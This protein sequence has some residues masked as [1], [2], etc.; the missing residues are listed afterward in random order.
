MNLNDGLLT[1]KNERS[2]RTYDLETESG[3]QVHIQHWFD[4]L[5][6]RTCV[7][8]LACSVLLLLFY[9]VETL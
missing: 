4:G 6:Q 3:K 8:T 1:S 2:Y 5:A 7:C 9:A